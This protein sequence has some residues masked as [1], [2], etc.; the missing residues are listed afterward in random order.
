M[1]II[2]ILKDGTELEDI[3]GHVVKSEEVPLLY[4]TLKKI[5]SEKCI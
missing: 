5:Q 3:N 1:K 4:E 2:H